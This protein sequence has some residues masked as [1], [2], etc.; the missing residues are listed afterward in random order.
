MRQ[1]DSVNNV[2]VNGL[3]NITVHL[4]GS[5]IIAIME[6]IMKPQ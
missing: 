2:S 1:A 3:K 6:M 5:Y 4:D